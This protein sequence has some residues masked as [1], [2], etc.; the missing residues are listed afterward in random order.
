MV[1]MAVLQG[2]DSSFELTAPLVLNALAHRLMNQVNTFPRGIGF[3]F[4]LASE[5]SDL[6]MADFDEGAFAEESP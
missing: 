6:T 5:V 4:D 1:A 2:G 3:L